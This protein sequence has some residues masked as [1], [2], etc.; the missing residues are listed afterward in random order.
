[1]GIVRRFPI[2]RAHIVVVRFQVTC[3]EDSV[4]RLVAT[5]KRSGRRET[6][7]M[8]YPRVQTHVVEHWFPKGFR[9]APEMTSRKR[10]AER[11]NNP[12]CARRGSADSAYGTP[13]ESLRYAQH[14]SGAA[15]GGPPLWSARRVASQ[16]PWRAHIDRRSSDVPPA[17]MCGKRVVAWRTAKNRIRTMA[18]NEWNIIIRF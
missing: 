17:H 7:S 2:K 18:P 1:M 8:P 6:R 16:P 13:K 15:I 11:A 10:P 5:K 4:V 3:A 9:A 12:R 14:Y